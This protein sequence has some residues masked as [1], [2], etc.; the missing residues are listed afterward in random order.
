MF[1]RRISMPL[2]QLLLPTIS[3]TGSFM[4][5]I[6]LILHYDILFL[7]VACRLVAGRPRDK[8]KYNSR[9]WVTA[10][11]RSMFARKQQQRN[12][13]FWAVPAEM[14]FTR[15]WK[16]LSLLHIVKPAL[17]RTQPPIQWVPVALWAGVKRPGHE[18]D[19]SRSS[20]AEVTNGGAIPSLPHMSSWLSAWTSFKECILL[21]IYIYIY[22]RQHNK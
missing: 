8:Q 7:I 3:R 16:D 14:L 21:Y 6:C 4:Y 17:R 15:Q 1:F 20:R 12:G 19:Y 11:Q 22:N 9:Y 2:Y 10:S 13:V 5:S 18:A